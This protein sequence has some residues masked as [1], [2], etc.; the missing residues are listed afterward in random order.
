MRYDTM[1]T[2]SSD[3]K[4]LTPHEAIADNEDHRA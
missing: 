4:R 3:R 2:E 1:T